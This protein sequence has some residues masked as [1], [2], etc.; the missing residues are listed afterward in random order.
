M[1]KIFTKN[2]KKSFFCGG[3]GDQNVDDDK[4]K[5]GMLIKQKDTDMLI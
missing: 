3:C 4:K 1:Q 2:R 5:N